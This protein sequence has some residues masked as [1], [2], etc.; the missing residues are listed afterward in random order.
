MQKLKMFAIDRSFFDTSRPDKE[1]EP[2]GSASIA[3]VKGISE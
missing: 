2:L 3:Y 1:K